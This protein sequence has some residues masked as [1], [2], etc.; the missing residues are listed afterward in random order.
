MFALDIAGRGDQNVYEKVIAAKT[1]AVVVRERSAKR[2]K[3]GAKVV[4]ECDV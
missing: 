4:G 1:P 3:T 2:A